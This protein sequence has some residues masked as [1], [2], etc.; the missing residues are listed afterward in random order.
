MHLMNDHAINMQNAPIEELQ[1]SI[2]IK[3]YQAAGK[4]TGA[5]W[6]FVDAFPVGLGEIGLDWGSNDTAEELGVGMGKVGMPLRVAAT[7][8]GNSPSLDVTLNLLSQDKIVER[9]NKALTFIANREN[10]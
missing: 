10:S 8:S 1:C 7:G 5:N 9:I 6:T 2:S 3:H 4:S